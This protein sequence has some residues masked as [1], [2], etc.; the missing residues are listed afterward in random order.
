MAF[1]TSADGHST[2]FD[3]IAWAVA[4]KQ[5]DNKASK[6]PFDHFDKPS[7]ESLY[8]VKLPKNIDLNKLALEFLKIGYK[9]NVM[10]SELS[11]KIV[12]QMLMLAT[13]KDLNSL[14][15]V[16]CVQSM[17]FD[18]M[19]SER[20]GKIIHSLQAKSKDDPSIAIQL[21]AMKYLRFNYENTQ[22]C[23][24]HNGLSITESLSDTALAS[25]T[26]IFREINL[27]YEKDQIETLR[28]VKKGFIKFTKFYLS[29]TTDER[30]PFEEE[31]E[32]FTKELTT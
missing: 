9:Y 11:N 4:K 13:K 2:N 12:H 16:L 31:K 10:G 20:V 32:L 7:K 30:R 18:T 23:E 29:K 28:Y 19:T 25:K 22:L 24:K 14:R 5:K 21:A 17:T 26:N 6:T 27:D 3:S 1:Q 15:F 8:G